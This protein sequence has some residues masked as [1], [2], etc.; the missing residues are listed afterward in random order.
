MRDLTKYRFNGQVYGKGRLIQA[1]LLDFVSVRKKISLEE[2]QSIFPKEL[3]G[4]YEI[5]EDVRLIKKNG[6]GDR[7]YKDNV[8]ILLDGT[9][10]LICN[11]WGSGNVHNIFVYIKKCYDYKFRKV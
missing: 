11:Q 9:K 2:L 4:K 7:Y 1:M 10:C 3:H 5:I 6:L 8:F